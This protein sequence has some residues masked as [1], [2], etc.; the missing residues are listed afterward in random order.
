MEKPKIVVVGSSNTDMVIKL[1]RLPGPGETIIGGD[2][3]MAAGGKGANQAV[4]AARL[5][6]EVTLVARVGADIFGGQAIQN[7]QKEGINADFIVED[8]EDPSG[9]AL[10]FVDR[11]G[12]NSIAVASGANENLSSEDVMK[13]KDVIASSEILIMQLETPL[14]TVKTAAKIA[15]ENGVKVILNPAP[16]R[17]LDGPIYQYLSILTPNE[18]EIELLTGMT[19]Q[20]EKSAE[21]AARVLLAK[22][23]GTIIVTLGSK[24]A[25]LVTQD[26]CKRIPG[27]EV[28]AVDATGAGDV[29]NGAL[30]VAIAEKKTLMDAL[31]FAN[32]AAALSVMKL[33]AQPSAPKRNEIENLLRERL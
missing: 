32:A 2:F 16:A 6:G 13:A 20:D 33:G 22:G 4:A 23:L 12:E 15:H 8:N 14:E 31:L 1:E 28:K 17:A 24:G 27:F 7:F 9:V 3:I 19:V 5:G 18:T 25:L 29:F 26:D 10:I 30:A 11:K 21:K